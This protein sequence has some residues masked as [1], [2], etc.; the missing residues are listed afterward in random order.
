MEARD[1]PSPSRNKVSAT[2]APAEPHGRSQRAVPL[3]SLNIGCWVLSGTKPETNPGSPEWTSWQVPPLS[4]CPQAT[5]SVRAWAS[6]KPLSVQSPAW[7]PGP[8]QLS[9]PESVCRQVSQTGASCPLGPGPAPM[10]YRQR[11]P[12]QQ[13][14]IRLRGYGEPRLR[15]T[16]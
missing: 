15:S 7:H 8:L 13:F 16:E 2:V 3:T 10:A 14:S 1:S 12:W 11:G 9:P 4:P 6:L 5:C